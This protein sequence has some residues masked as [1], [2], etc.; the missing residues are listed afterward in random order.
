MSIPLGQAHDSLVAQQ[1]LNRTE[2]QTIKN[3]LGLKYLTILNNVSVSANGNQNSNQYSPSNRHQIS[4]AFN[5]ATLTGAQM[6]AVIDFSFDGGTTWNAVHSS[7]YEVNSANQFM[8]LITLKQG[9]IAPLIRIRAY[10]TTDT[11]GNISIF[12]SQ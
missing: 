5:S 3:S 7:A 8:R 1:T 6:S 9:V 4:F 11:A 2:L 12:V 10:N